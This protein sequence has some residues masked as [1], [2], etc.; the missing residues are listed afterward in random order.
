MA[1]KCLMID[2]SCKYSNIET[3]STRRSLTYIDINKYAKVCLREG[4][5][6]HACV[7]MYV[8]VVRVCVLHMLCVYIVRVNAIVCIHERAHCLC[9][10]CTCVRVHAF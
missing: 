4:V 2:L 10:I 5:H 8:C 1:V 9:Y 6:A 7:C 3:T